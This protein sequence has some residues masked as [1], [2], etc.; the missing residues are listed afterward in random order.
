MAT[1][2]FEFETQYGTYADAITYDEIEAPMTPEE[3][4]VEKQRRLDN[5][6]AIVQGTRS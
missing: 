1:V 5:W 2:V 3:I 4:E 6:L